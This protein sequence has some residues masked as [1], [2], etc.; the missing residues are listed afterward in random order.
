M[1]T[2]LLNILAFLTINSFLIAQTNFVSSIVI[3]NNGDSI[4]GSIDYR[5][6]KNNPQ[7]INF[8]SIANEKHRFDASSIREFYIPSAKEVY[9]SFTV[10]MD[11]LP[12]NPDEAIKNNFIDSPVL[13]KTVFLLQLINHPALSLY[14][15]VGNGKEHFYLRVRDAEPI[16]LIHHY[17]FDQSSKLVKEYVAFRDQLST[18]LEGCPDIT[19]T[20]KNLKFRKNEIQNTILKYL[21]C[22][23]PGSLIS[24][25]RKDSVSVKFGVVAGVML[26][27]FKF[28]GT[29]SLV[30]ENYSNNVSPI[31]GLSL[32]IGL[33]RNRNKWHIVN[34]L[35]YKSYKT[36]STFTRPYNYTYSVESDVDLQFSYAQLNTILRYVFQLNSPLKPYI[37]LGLGNAIMI[38]ENENRLQQTFS[39]GS[40]EDSKAIDGPK[41]YEFSLLGG[42]GL[43]LNHVQLELRHARNKKGFS[44]YQTLDVNPKSFQVI[45]VYQ[46]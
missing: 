31:V 39:Y 23:A 27:T 38:S 25:K 37:N 44:P 28:E 14:Q 43:M 24:V 17:L 32:D 5:N 40:E 20:V 22:S 45:V 19:K 29:S 41:R 2:L 16:E 10:K 12:G 21:Q 46:F 1:K 36:R 30:D 13:N 3:N 33:S 7:A 26:N 6:W 35:I 11:M 4:Y 8:I 34:E 15:F 9:A 42:A 18:V